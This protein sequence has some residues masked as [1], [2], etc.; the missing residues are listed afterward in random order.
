MDTSELAQRLR[1]M[2]N[3]MNN[4]EQFEGLEQLKTELAL[5][6]L[7]VVVD[8]DSQFAVRLNMSETAL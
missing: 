7:E 2:E 8:E 4:Q 3:A 1:V 6:G 5:D